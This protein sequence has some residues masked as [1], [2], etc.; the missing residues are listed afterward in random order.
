MRRRRE[1]N[2]PSTVVSSSCH[3]A[4]LQEIC[5]LAC[6]RRR[7]RA[8]GTREESVIGETVWRGRKKKKKMNRKMWERRRKRKQG[9]R[10]SD[11]PPWSPGGN[12]LVKARVNST[13]HFAGPRVAAPVRK[14]KFS[15]LRPFP[16]LFSFFR[17]GLCFFYLALSLG[18]FASRAA[19]FRLRQ[20]TRGNKYIKR[21][22][23]F[24][25]INFHPYAPAYISLPKWPPLQ[26]YYTTLVKV[27]R[28]ML[29]KLASV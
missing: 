28:H 22:K 20:P 24:R 25:A 4:T 19:G 12:K 3:L 8:S 18:S 1:T 10:Y 2:L 26:M 27:Y 29:Q 17:F 14:R 7:T 6:H 21:E 11:E 23:R 5:E 9:G 15:P 13:S 16:L